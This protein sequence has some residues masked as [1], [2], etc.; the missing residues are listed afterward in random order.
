MIWTVL[1][2]LP[3]L[4]LPP[5]TIPPTTI[6]PTIPPLLPPLIP[7]VSV[8]PPIAPRLLLKTTSHPIKHLSCRFSSESSG[9]LFYHPGLAIFAKSSFLEWLYTARGAVGFAVQ[10]K[11]NNKY[12]HA[13]FAD[14]GHLSE[15]FSSLSKIQ[16]RRGFNFQVLSLYN[17]LNDERPRSA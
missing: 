3:I 9:T 4:I 12:S 7:F 14:P 8:P 10:K 11:G 2:L 15:W 6:P 5:T 16:H 17:R 13:N 1:P